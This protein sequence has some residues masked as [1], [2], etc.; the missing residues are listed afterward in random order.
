[1]CMSLRGQPSWSVN[2]SFNLSRVSARGNGESRGGQRWAGGVLAIFYTAME[3]GT[4]VG[5]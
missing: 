2:T 3:V 4:Y 5:T 1:M